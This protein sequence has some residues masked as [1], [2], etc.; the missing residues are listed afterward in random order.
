MFDF[1]LLKVK[2]FLSQND[3]EKAIHA[4]IS[5]HIDDCNALYDGINQGFLYAGLL[6]NTRSHSHITPGLYSLH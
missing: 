4:F 5:S 6:T 3:L 2:P 1:L